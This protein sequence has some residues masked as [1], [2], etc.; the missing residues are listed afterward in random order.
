MTIYVVRGQTGEYS[1]RSEWTVKAF[2]HEA[3]AKKFVVDCTEQG[4]ELNSKHN[5]KLYRVDDTT[6]QTWLDPKFYCDYSGFN[7][8]YDSVELIEEEAYDG[9]PQRKIILD[10]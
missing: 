9:P 5:G 10:D 6:K 4:N 8:W 2:V 1:D 3:A 7:Y